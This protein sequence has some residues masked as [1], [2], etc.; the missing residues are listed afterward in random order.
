M[1]EAIACTNFI[2]ILFLFLGLCEPSDKENYTQNKPST[3]D[4]DLWKKEDTPNGSDKNK[5]TIEYAK[6]ICTVKSVK[7]PGLLKNLSPLKKI[8]F[9]I[10]SVDDSDDRSTI[11]LP[12]IP[13]D[14]SVIG[15]P[16]VAMKILNKA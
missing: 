13:S 15:L 12:R 6:A 9:K 2:Q 1:A 16:S 3:S 5:S 8:K 7:R 4:E 10:P 11:S 14:E